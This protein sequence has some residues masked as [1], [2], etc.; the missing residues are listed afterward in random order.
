MVAPDGDWYFIRSDKPREEGDDE[1]IWS[2]C[3]NQIDDEEESDTEIYSDSDVPDT[4]NEVREQYAVGDLPF[5]Q[6]RTKADPGKIDPFYAAAARAAT[7]MPRLRKMFLETEVEGR[8]S[9]SFGMSYW[10][11]GE[12]SSKDGGPADTEIPGLDWDV[13]PSGYVPEESTIEIWRQAKGV[14]GRILSRIVE[15]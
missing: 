11:P 13:G 8:N 1:D 10:A 15:I 4:Y 5:D 14:D 12:A 2:P 9:F 7:Q 6:F 3:L